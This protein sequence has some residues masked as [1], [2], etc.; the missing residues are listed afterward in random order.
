MLKLPSTICTPEELT[1]L[2][3][4]I[5]EYAKWYSHEYVKHRTGVKSQ[6]TP[7]VIS[8][9]TTSFL[10]SIATSHALRPEQ[11]DE[12]INSLESH[13]R[14]APSITLTLAAPAPQSLRKTLTAWCREQLSPDILVSFTFNR[15]LLG[16]MVVRYGS[17]IYDWSWR[18][19]LLDNQVSFTEVMNRV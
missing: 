7:P 9:S 4:E 6:S 10:R 2:I 8:P 1:A 3:L 5:R 13:K 14:S 12:I 15:T 19:K 18:R 17:R 16:G 11:I